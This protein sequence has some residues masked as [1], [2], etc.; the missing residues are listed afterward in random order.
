MYEEIFDGIGRD[1]VEVV[2]VTFAENH[3]EMVLIK[4][5]PF[6]EIRHLVTPGVTGWAQIHGLRGDTSIRERVRYDNYYIEHW[7]MWLDIK[8][9]LRGR[10]VADADPHELVPGG[11]E[12]DLVAAIAISIVGVQHRWMAVGQRAELQCRRAAERRADRGGR[13]DRPAW[14]APRVPRGGDG[15]C[16]RNQPR[17]DR[18]RRQL[19]QE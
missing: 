2:T 3:D 18:F 13:P 11:V 16:R 15:G 5:I 1:P 7:S 17:R 14:H 4:E 12:L 9:L 6:Y 19:P 8:V 10:F